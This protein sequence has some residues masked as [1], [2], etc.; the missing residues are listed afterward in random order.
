M[1]GVRRAWLDVS[2]GERRGVVT[3]DGRPERLVIE[4][5]VLD[6]E[7]AASPA[8]APVRLGERWRVRIGARSPDRREAF[9]D[10]GGPRAPAR[11]KGPWPRAR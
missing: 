7:A 6:G 4:R 8:P 11:R 9:V 2:P 3:L 10:L 5:D 1:S